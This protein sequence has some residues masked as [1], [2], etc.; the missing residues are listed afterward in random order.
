MAVLKKGVFRLVGD[1]HAVNIQ[2]EKVP[3]VT[4]N[5]ESEM[6]HFWGATCFGKLDL[7]ML[8]RYW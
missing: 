3:G 4:P 2:I 6:A 1:Y 8:Q 5:H 7:D